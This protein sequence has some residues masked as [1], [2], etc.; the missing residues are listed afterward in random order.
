[1]P[2]KENLF[3]SSKDKS[4]KIS[5]T[6]DKTSC[7]GKNLY[8]ADRNV[9]KKLYHHLGKNKKMETDLKNLDSI[10]KTY[11][12]RKKKDSFSTPAHIQ[13]GGVTYLYN[14]NHET[15]PNSNNMTDNFIKND[16]TRSS[17]IPRE[18]PNRK[19]PLTVSVKFF[20]TLICCV[21]F[22]KIVASRRN[23]SSEIKIRNVTCKFNNN[24]HIKS[25][26]NAQSRS[27]IVSGYSKRNRSLPNSN[28]VNQNVS[29]EHPVDDRSRYTISNYNNDQTNPP[30]T[31][32]ISSSIPAN[33]S[34]LINYA[35]EIS[36]D[37]K[38]NDLIYSVSETNQNNH[39]TLNSNYNGNVYYYD[40]YKEG[41]QDN[42]LPS[43]NTMDINKLCMVIDLDETLVHSSFKVWIL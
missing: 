5:M 33:Q 18:S 17:K 10:N 41:L 21:K 14:N 23:S 36:L 3:T 1:M 19:T 12:K 8:E 34:Y 27:V 29:S 2:H 26:A 13:N 39:L 35:P 31:I 24:E 38:K 16:G 32:H 43:A 37:L 42:L 6:I 22:K 40:D 11:G 7:N 28:S 15:K 9:K 4:K 25:T 20:E 30:R